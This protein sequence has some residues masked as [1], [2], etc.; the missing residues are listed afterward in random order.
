MRKR[1]YFFEA[2]EGLRDAWS[3]ASHELG[4]DVDIHM[5]CGPEELDNLFSQ[6]PPDLLLLACDSVALDPPTVF[7]W[8]SRC[9]KEQVPL[10]ISSIDDEWRCRIPKDGHCSFVSKAETLDVFL[11]A[12]SSALKC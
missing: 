9:N 4:F 6:T 10:L 12:G 5:C 11:S 7:Q 8:V 3:M 2:H 1:I